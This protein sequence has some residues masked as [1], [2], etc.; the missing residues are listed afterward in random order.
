MFLGART[1]FQ[2]IFAFVLT[3]KILTLLQGITETIHGRSLDLYY[4]VNQVNLKVV[5][6]WD[7]SGN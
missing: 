1:L 4:V 7:I 2:F 6:K 3:V 5:T